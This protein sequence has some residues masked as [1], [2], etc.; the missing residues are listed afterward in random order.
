MPFKRRLAAFL[1]GPE[2]LAHRIVNYPDDDFAL[3]AQR[4]RNAKMRNAVKI[5][6]RAVERIDDPLMI[7]FLIAHNSFL[8]IKRMLG[9]FF[10]ERFGD[11][12]LSAH[13]DFEFDVVRLERIDAERLLKLVPEQ[14]AGGARGF[15][16]RV[17][18]MR[19]DE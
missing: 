5:I 15:D 16:R 6:H 2:F 14:F 17:E 9:K 1:R 12:F 18:V 11:Q 19:H 10:Q 8:A 4:N 7:A 3:E 13:I